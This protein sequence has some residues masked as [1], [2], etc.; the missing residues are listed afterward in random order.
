MIKKTFII[1]AV[2]LFFGFLSFSQNPNSLSIDS[3]YAWAKRNYPLVKQYSLIQQSEQYSI[4]NANKGFLPQFVIAGQATYQS[5]VTQ[6]PISMPG[7]N[8]E[9]LNKDQYKVYA[10]VSESITGLFLVKDKKELITTNSEIEQKKIDI[11]LYKLDERINQLYFGILLIDEQIKQTELIK[12][13]IQT[14]IDKTNSMIENGIALKTGSD[15]LKAELLK[16]KQRTIELKASRKG[17]MDMLSMFIN[18]EITENTTFEKPIEQNLSTG[19]N[20]PETALFD[21]QK[22]TFDI[23]NKLIN[24]KSLPQIGLFIQGGL[25]RPAL[26]MLSNDIN[27]YYIGGLRVSWNLSS[28]YTSA[29]EKQILTVNQNSIEISKSV[30]L[31]NTKVLQKQQNSEVAKLEELINTDNEI[32]ELR[33]SIKLTT[34]KQLEN[35]TAT[36]SDFLL[37]VNSQDQAEQNLILHKIQ[38]L[39]AQYNYKTTSGN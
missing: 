3:C 37:A 25:G 4:D 13:D 14:G 22:R 24:A 36:T 15:L 9:P 21:M 31:F 20:R 23:Q 7:V 34:K 29:K 10:E 39:L 19:V 35:G 33:Q 28:F 2:S 1:L 12:K 16:L 26:N 30:F 32:I 8:I 38:L 18:Q 27:T 6:I 5:E 11:E 17:F